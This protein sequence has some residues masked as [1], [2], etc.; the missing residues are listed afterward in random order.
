MI[1]ESIHL[2]ATVRTATGRSASIA[3][4]EHD[5][6]P[7]VLYGHGL[8]THHLAIAKGMFDK[9][10]QHAGES[11]L[12]DLTVEGKQPVKVLVYEV[13]RDPLS[14]QVEHVD[15]YQVRMDEKIKTDVELRFDGEAPAVKELGGILV[16]NYDTV[17]VECLPA[18][19]PH[20]IVVPI[21]SL[22]T[23]NDNIR[24][25]DLVLPKGVTIDHDMEDTVVTV[26]EPRSEEELA[27]LNETVKENVESVEV[28]GKKEKEEE[29]ATPEGEDA[30]AAAPTVRAVKAEKKAEKKK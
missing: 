27:A 10:F 4:R 1:Q 19:L 12:V 8:S 15:F 22:K 28:A 14:N 3:L 30:A 5:Q 25:K 13:K 26:S 20:E 11:T 2:A 21:D 9:A 6:I 18:D 24:F 17:Q 23:F 16:K 7:A 29:P